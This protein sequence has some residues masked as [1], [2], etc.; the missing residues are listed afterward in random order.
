MDDQICDQSSPRSVRA[1]WDVEFKVRDY[2]C[3]MGHVVNHSVYLNYLEHARH[4]FLRS[5]NIDF[6]GLAKR[7]VFLVVTRIEADYKASLTSSDEFV[8]R[9]EVRRKGRLRIQFNQQIYRVFDGRLMFSAVVIGAA[10][11]QQGRPEMPAEFAQL[12]EASISD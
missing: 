4:E 2:E 1:M 8:V 10:V 7:G 6:G 11:N 9:S 3:D 12:F 5:K